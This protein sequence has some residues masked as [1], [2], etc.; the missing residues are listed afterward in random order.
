MKRE[1]MSATPIIDK[2]DEKEE[3]FIALTRE[4]QTALRETL[5][6]RAY[7]AIA[8]AVGTVHF[9]ESTSIFDQ[10]LYFIKSYT[11]DNFSLLNI[12][13]YSIPFGGV[14]LAFF[15]VSQ[16]ALIILYAPLGPVGQFLSFRNMAKKFAGRVD[17]L[18]G[19]I[20]YDRISSEC[21]EPE[22]PEPPAVPEEISV[23]LTEVMDLP[24]KKP[25]QQYTVRF[26]ILKIKLT[27]KVKFPLNDMQVLQYC[28][29]NYSIE[30]IVKKTKF[31]QLK[32]D[33]ILRDYQKKNLVEIKRVVQ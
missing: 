22:S 4:I 7:V 6:T 5:V 3:Q 18:I 24:L 11:H 12:G 26:P 30:E 32:V 23:P 8:D 14:N 10:Y 33:M 28:D 21:A 1:D 15:K 19:S 25:Q 16:K 13:D 29:G 20:D 27:D 9:V 31:P 2:L 17:D